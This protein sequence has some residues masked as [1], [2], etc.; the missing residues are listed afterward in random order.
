MSFSRKKYNNMKLHRIVTDLMPSYTALRR[1][2]QK[3][4]DDR[5]QQVTGM[6]MFWCESVGRDF[7]RH[8]SLQRQV[9]TACRKERCT[10]CSRRVTRLDEYAYA[11]VP[12]LPKRSTAAPPTPRYI[13]RP[14]PTPTAPSLQRQP[15]DGIVGGRPPEL[16]HDSDTCVPS[17]SSIQMRLQTNDTGRNCTKTFF[18]DHVRSRNIHSY[19][20]YLSHSFILRNKITGRFKC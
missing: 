12:P 20:K 1:Y 4:H 13:R 9:K 15:V 7:T 16:V 6:T 19:K 8:C 11:D 14:H 18:V 3:I 10:N 5:P 17:S 2:Q